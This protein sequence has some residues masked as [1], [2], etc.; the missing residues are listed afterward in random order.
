MGFLGLS[1]GNPFASLDGGIV[2]TGVQHPYGPRPVAKKGTGTYYNPPQKRGAYVPPYAP[3]YNPTPQ[4]KGGYP[5]YFLQPQKTP[6]Y[7][8]KTYGGRTYGG[9][10]YG[11]KIYTPSYGKRTYT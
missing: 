11:G 10:T 4:K 1:L 9:K 7:G 5:P 3:H 2:G 6:T 8:G